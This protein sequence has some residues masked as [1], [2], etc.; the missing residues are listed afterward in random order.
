MSEL[1]Q[2]P[3]GQMDEFVLEL[4]PV[5]DSVRTARLFGASLARQFDC[6]EELVEDI[7]LALSEGMNKALRPV[8]GGAGRINLIARKSDEVLF[9]NLEGSPG[10]GGPADQQV[11]EQPAETQNMEE[12]LILALFP[13]AVFGQGGRQTAFTVPLV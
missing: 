13:G 9:F 12:E 5:G 3:P 11:H 10:P 1:S 8:A 7:K 2:R 6:D 4:P